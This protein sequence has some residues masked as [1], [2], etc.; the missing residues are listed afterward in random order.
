MM[1]PTMVLTASAVYPALAGLGLLVAPEAMMFGAGAGTPDVSLFVLRSYGGTL[2]GLAVLAGMARNAGASP[3]RDAIFL[4]STVGY[5]LSGIV[6]VYSQLTA[7]GAAAA[8]WIFAI[9]NLL[10][11]VWFFL[12]GRAS[13]GSGVG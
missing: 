1:K 13:M 4:G 7:P 8:D 10:F 9:V 11:A 2:L 5:A 6:L 3:A 12:V